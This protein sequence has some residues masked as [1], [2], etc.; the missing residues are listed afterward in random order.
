MARQAPKI[1]GAV[2]IGLGSTLLTGL[3]IKS[4]YKYYPKNSEFVEVKN[5]KVNKKIILNFKNR[6]WLIVVPWKNIEYAFHRFL[7]HTKEFNNKYNIWK[8]FFFRRARNKLL[9]TQYLEWNGFER[10]LLCYHF[11]CKLEI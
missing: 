3:C 9:N 4:H 10:Q 5:I 2:G 7:K 11:G 8:S 1:S 6:T